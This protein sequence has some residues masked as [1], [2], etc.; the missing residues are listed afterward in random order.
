MPWAQK[1]DGSWTD[2]TLSDL[3]DRAYRLHDNAWTYCAYKMTDGRITRSEAVRIAA[4]FGMTDPDR[5]TQAI[6]EL[7][8]AK[9]WTEDLHGYSLVGWLDQ[10]RSRK[11]VLQ[12]REKNRKKQAAYRRRMAES[13]ASE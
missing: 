9:L 10:N 8:T 5:V 7:V 3:S 12:D 2:P 11:Q 6:S 1:D 13:E 4:M